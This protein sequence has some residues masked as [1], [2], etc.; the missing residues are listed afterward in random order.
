VQITVNAITTDMGT[1]ADIF[2]N[3]VLTFAQYGVECWNSADRTPGLE[4][5]ETSRCHFSNC[6]LREAAPNSQGFSPTF[7]SPLTRGNSGIN[8][9]GAGYFT[10][11]YQP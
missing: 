6:S 4:S 5:P 11:W 1:W 2:G 7:S 3:S 8:S 9:T 10:T